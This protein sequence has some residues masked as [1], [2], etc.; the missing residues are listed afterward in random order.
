MKCPE[1]QSVYEWPV[2]LEDHE[3]SGLAVTTLNFQKLWRRI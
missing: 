1:T 3:P 2:K